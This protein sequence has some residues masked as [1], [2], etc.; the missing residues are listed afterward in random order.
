MFQIDAKKL[1]YFDYP[2]F[3]AVLAV[4]IIGIFTIGT[5]EVH[6][7]FALK[8]IIWVL[9]GAV[10]AIAV[11]SADTKRIKSITVYLYIFSIIL[12][13]AVFANGILSH[14][15]KRWISLYFFHIQP[16]EFRLFPYT[17]VNSSGIN[18]LIAI[19]FLLNLIGKK[20]KTK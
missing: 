14:G 11:S 19:C 15:A 4:N 8:Q 17:A 2:L 18:L 5:T 6:L 16:S 3:F 10:L 20:I 9:A 13:A 1:K 7:N 12:L